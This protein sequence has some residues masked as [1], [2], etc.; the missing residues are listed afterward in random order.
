MEV[1]SGIPY[2]QFIQQRLLDPL[3]MKETS[4][5]PNAELAARLVLTH[6]FNA[7]TGAME[8]LKLN[9]EIVNDPEKCGTTPPIILTQF[10]ASMIQNY[11]QQFAR[12][13]GGLFSTPPDIA[14]FCQM[15]LGGGTYQGKQYL[16]SAAF[17]Q[18]TS[19]QTGDLVVGNGLDGYGIGC[20]VRRKAIAGEPSIGSFGASW[21]RKTQMWIDPQ[22][23]IAMVLMVQ[24]SELNNKQLQLCTPPI[25]NR[26]L[27]PVRQS[28]AT[29]NNA[30]NQRK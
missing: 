23:Q 9:P 29:T 27:S 25:R 12:P 19:I 20:F 16:S 30:S 28:E 4:F 15:L 1:T 6:D 7:K 5:W 2:A 18:M 21:S 8:P 13:S 3:G 24:A 11:A 22:N 17:K 26:R 10:P 14:K